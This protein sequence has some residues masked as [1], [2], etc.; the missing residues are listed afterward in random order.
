MSLLCHCKGGK[1]HYAFLRS[2][3]CG[4]TLAGRSYDHSEQQV[5]SLEGEGFKLSRLVTPEVSSI[6]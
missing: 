6:L 3:L 4:C 5:L 1:E 2:I